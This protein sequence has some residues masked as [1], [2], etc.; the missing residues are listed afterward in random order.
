[1]AE[2]LAQEQARTKPKLEEFIAVHL[3]DELQ[4]NLLVFLEYC[5]TKKIS[6]KWSSTNTWTLKYKSKSI[7][8]IHVS[9]ANWTIGVGFVEL[10]QYDDFIVEESLQNDIL[11]NI[12]H[13]TGCNTYCAPGYSQEILGKQYRKLCRAIYFLDGK[14]CINF[15]NPHAKSMDKIKRMI[16]FRLAI[17][18]GTAKRPVFDPAA[19]GL[20]RIN[21]NVHITG[22]TDLH[23]NPIKNEITSKSSID[24]LFDGKYDSYA[25][26]WANENSY[27]IVIQLNEPIKFTKYSFVT[28]LQLQ[29]PDSWKLYGTT[30]LNEHWTLIDEQ[31][32]FPKPVTSYTERVFTIDAPKTYQYYRY[33]FKKCKFDLSQV[34]LYLCP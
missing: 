16:D 10:I 34:H 11:D 1:M 15:T 24:K 33:V 31:A 6:Y 19:D 29:V 9:D 14:V 13:C 12:R 8:L 25:R 26:F 22:I 27:D 20:T 4:R 18:H 3:N 32:R 7:G 23:G 28:S 21:N 30:S 2:T 5:A 17:P